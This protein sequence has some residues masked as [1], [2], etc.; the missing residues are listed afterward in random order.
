MFE[1]IGHVHWKR[2]TPVDR[3][4]VK[5]KEREQPKRKDKVEEEEEMAKNVWV[6]YSLGIKHS[7]R[8]I[9]AFLFRS[10]YFVLVILL[11]VSL[12]EAINRYSSDTKSPSY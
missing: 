5:R 10:L 3:E 1:S 8:D 12:F 6:K 9:V 7:V 2:N 4:E 11:I